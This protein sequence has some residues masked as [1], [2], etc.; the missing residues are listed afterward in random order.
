VR[1]SKKTNIRLYIESIVPDLPTIVSFTQ[2]HYLLHVMRLKPGDRLRIFNCSVG[3]FD[4]RL[5]QRKHDVLVIPLACVRAP[6]PRDPPTWL[7]FSPIKPHLTHF[8]VEKATELGISDIQPILFDL[9]QCREVNVSK[10]QAIAIEASEQCERL[11]VPHIHTSQKLASFL[12][13]LP[14]VRWFAAVERCGDAPTLQSTNEA[15]GVLIGPEGGFSA[16]EKSSISSCMQ[17]VSL[18][19]NVLRSETAAICALSRLRNAINHP[20]LS[21]PF[22][23]QVE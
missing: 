22:A 4:A 18:G 20:H 6:E 2:A 3:E 1:T 7:A 12:E 11:T 8:V 15:V 16:R 21:D 23:P 17:V 5:E 14:T 10:L 19:A 13:N 9:T